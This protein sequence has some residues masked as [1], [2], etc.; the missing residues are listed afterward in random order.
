MTGNTTKPVCAR[1]AVQREPA[2]TSVSEVPIT[3][4]MLRS[5]SRALS[6]G[7]G[8][9]GANAGGLYLSAEAFGEG[10]C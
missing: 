3:L 8:W 6:R 2:W 4:A 5:L 7:G 1:F 9:V 10:G